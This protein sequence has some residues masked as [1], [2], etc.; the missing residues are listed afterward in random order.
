MKTTVADAEKVI[1][2]GE[3]EPMFVDVVSTV[4][5]RLR[6]ANVFEFAETFWNCKFVFE[7]VPSVMRIALPIV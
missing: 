2:P 6:F 3:K 5:G 4:A 1:V 7:T